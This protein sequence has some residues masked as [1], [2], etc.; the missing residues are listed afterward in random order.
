VAAE[1]Q[2]GTN[3]QTKRQVVTRSEGVTPS[4]KYLK[5]LCD[6]S[7]LSLW[8]YPGIFRDQ[9]RPSGKGDGKEVA[10]VLVVFENNVI[11]FSDK[12]IHFEKTE[13]IEVAWGR[14]FRNRHSN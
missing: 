2:D 6:R 14:W 5:K 1:K 9:G 7:L 12:H 13:K 10:D 8:S 3:P 4:E 11:I